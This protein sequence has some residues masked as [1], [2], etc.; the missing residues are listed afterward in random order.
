MADWV[1]PLFTIVVAVALLV[2]TVAIAAMFLGITRLVKRIDS[3]AARVQGR[4]YPL[5]SQIQLHLDELQ[6]RI[7]C[8]VTEAADLV[9][10]A[11]IEVERT[12]RKISEVSDELRTKLVR[13]DQ[14]V[15]ATLHTVD[16]TGS[17]IRHAVLAPVR[18]MRALTA[19]IQTG[20]NTYR[21]RS[22]QAEEWNDVPEE[23]IR[24]RS[25]AEAAE[26]RRPFS[27]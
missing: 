15:G 22:R 9:H 7:A 27:S 14:K 20:I 3:A 25:E 23:R 12:D 26:S 4:L 24:Y 6:P 18:S 13:L 11:R 5:I 10:S 17:R 19:G 8:A 2:E 21:E 1:M 16:V